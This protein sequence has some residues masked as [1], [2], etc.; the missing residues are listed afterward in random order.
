[1]TGAHEPTLRIAFGA[2]QVTV[3]SDVPEVLTRVSCE[4]R[5]LLTAAPGPAKPVGQ[6]EVVR[7]AEGY[8]LLHEGQGGMRDRVLPGILRSL[9]H[10]VIRQLTEARPDLLWLHAGAAALGGRAALL[11]GAFG[12]GKSTLVTHLCMRG[13]HYLSDDVV[14]LDPASGMLLP[15]PLTPVVRQGTGRLLPR[16]RLSEL[17]RATV[18]LAAGAFCRTAVPVGVVIFPVYSPQ[19]A[20]QLRPCSPADAALELLRRCLNIGSHQGAAAA[21]LTRLAIHVPS[22]HLL[23][24]GTQRAAALVDAAMHG[25]DGQTLTWQDA[26]QTGGGHAARA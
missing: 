1:M 26:G 11:A 5:E 18:N 22:F 16:D 4:F 6:L 10:E 20:P 15:F 9:R 8:E 12:H 7:T 3:R 19:V 13:W 25:A 21:Y 24:G 14:P 2:H 17:S 23:H